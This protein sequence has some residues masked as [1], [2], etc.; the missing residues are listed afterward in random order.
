MWIA[1]S[2]RGH[3]S[4][5]VKSNFETGEY[6]SNKVWRWLN[7][8]PH[9]RNN[10]KILIKFFAKFSQDK[11]NFKIVIYLYINT[12]SLNICIFDIPSEWLTKVEFPFFCI[13][14]FTGENG[15]TLQ[16]VVSKSERGKTRNSSIYQHFCTSTSKVNEQCF[17]SF[18]EYEV[19]QAWAPSE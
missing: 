1:V 17:V 14:L 12:H 2:L 13:W 18:L 11:N 15:V 8:D 3:M 6:E 4:N 5:K 16:L 19:A 9:E 10:K 7:C